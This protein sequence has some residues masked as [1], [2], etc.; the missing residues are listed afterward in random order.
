[1]GD[2]RKKEQRYTSSCVPLFYHLRFFWADVFFAGVVRLPAGFFG[3]G[4]VGLP[5]RGGMARIRHFGPEPI[6]SSR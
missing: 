5:C 1:M 2:D 6:K 4:A 3:G